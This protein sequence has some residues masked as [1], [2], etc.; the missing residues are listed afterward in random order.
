MFVLHHH[1]FKSAVLKLHWSVLLVPYLLL[2]LGQ[3]LTVAAAFEFISAQSPSSMKG[4]LV[5]VFISVKAFFQ[6][7]SG[8]ILIPFARKSLWDSEHMRRH[9]PVT[10]CG[11][12]YLLFTCVAALI[13]LI[14]LLVV[15][16][17]YKYRERD[18]RPYDQRFAVDV[19]SRYLQ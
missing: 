12:G 14:L 9:P 11:F 7:I 16:R 10:N 8:I 15:A 19:Y 5:G 6:L 1:V 3:P 17:R 2:G 18:D 4:L 13:G